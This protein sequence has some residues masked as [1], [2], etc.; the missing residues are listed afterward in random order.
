MSD[1]PLGVKLRRSL[2]QDLVCLCDAWEQIIQSRQAEVVLYLTWMPND[3]EDNRPMDFDLESRTDYTTLDPADEWCISSRRQCPTCR[4][5][6]PSNMSDN[7]VVCRKVDMWEQD[8]QN[9]EDHSGCYSRTDIMDTVEGFNF[10]HLL[11]LSH[12]LLEGCV[13]SSQR[14]SRAMF[15]KRISR[16]QLWCGHK[17]FLMI[18]HG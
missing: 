3:T 15:L 2:P 1:D 10:I 9:T 17:Q 7:A 4:T 18:K 11:P 13:C 14:S 5:K 16:S 12:S 6:Y 8:D